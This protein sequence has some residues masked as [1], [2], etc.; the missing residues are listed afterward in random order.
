MNRNQTQDVEIDKQDVG[1][2]KQTVGNQTQN[3]GIEQLSVN[4]QKQN[5]RHPQN[6]PESIHDVGR[7]GG[8]P[9]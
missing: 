6:T 9:G 4:I 8:S 5:V 2:Q 3:D 1:I 7:Q